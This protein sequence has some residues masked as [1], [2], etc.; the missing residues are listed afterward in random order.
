GA[1]GSSLESDETI[2][3]ATYGYRQQ[4][5]QRKVKERQQR[6]RQQEDKDSST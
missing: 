5:R 1:L 2:R 4:L 3:S 6:D